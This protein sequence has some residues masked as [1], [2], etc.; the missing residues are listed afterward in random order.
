MV[1]QAEQLQLESALPLLKDVLYCGKLKVVPLTIIMW[2]IYCA[3][4]VY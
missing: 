1:A 3:H 2:N 4:N